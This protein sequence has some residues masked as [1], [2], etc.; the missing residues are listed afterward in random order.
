M[1]VKYALHNIVFEWD[2]QKAATNIRKHSITFELA[3]E[4]FFDP[5]VRYLDDEV[6]DGEL[7]ETIIGLATN[8]QLLYVVYVMREDV[9][10]VISARLVT[11]AE[12]E[13]Y[14]NQ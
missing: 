12:R 14:E 10:R 1:N 9:I 5:F 2:S 4:A 7:R 13:T 3:C 8:W 11:N 6:V